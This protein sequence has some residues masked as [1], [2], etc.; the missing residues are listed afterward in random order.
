M[1]GLDDGVPGPVILFVL[2]LALTAIWIMASRGRE[3]L[4]RSLSSDTQQT[5]SQRRREGGIARTPPTVNGSPV[6]RAAT[7]RHAD[8]A[9]QTPTADRADRHV[10]LGHR[11]VPAGTVGLWEVTPPRVVRGAKNMRQRPLIATWITRHE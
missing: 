4:I 2:Y 11:R 10:L 9:S 1:V 7:T 3:P 8:T 5:L 6:R